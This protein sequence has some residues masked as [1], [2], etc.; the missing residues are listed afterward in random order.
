M[1]AEPALRLRGTTER[2]E[3]SGLTLFPGN[4]RKGDIPKIRK[5]LRE[6]GQIQTVVVQKST[7][8]VL[9]GNHTVQAAEL[10]GWTEIDAYVVDVDDAE[11]LKINVALNK[12][13]DEGTYDFEALISQLEEIDDLVGTGWSPEELEDM[14][15]AYEPDA[16][17]LPPAPSAAELAARPEAAVG[18]DVRTGPSGDPD[19][20]DDS[21][22]APTDSDRRAKFTPDATRVNASRRLMVMD[23]PVDVFLWTSER[24]EELCEE[25]DIETNTEMILAL[26]AEATG[27]EAPA[28]SA[29]ENAGND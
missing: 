22:G 13:G 25:R 27:T 6:F 2:R 19:E 17:I 3:I 1:T 24:L 28:L 11:A 23:L 29:E 16:E 4:A 8:Y 26:I 12:L 7:D 10:E 20:V 14:I 15:V 9:G 21:Y 18:V 5:S